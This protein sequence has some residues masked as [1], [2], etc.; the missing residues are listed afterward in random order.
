MHILIVRRSTKIKIEEV[1]SLVTSCITISVIIAKSEIIVV[2]F[3]ET[4]SASAVISKA[5]PF[6]VV[7]MAVLVTAI[8][9]PIL[10]VI[11]VVLI[12]VTVAIVIVASTT[13]SV[14]AIVFFLIAAVAPIVVSW[15]IVSIV[16]VATY[17]G[18]DD[19]CLGSL[20][21]APG[22]V[23]VVL[24][25]LMVIHTIDLIL[26]LSFDPGGVVAIGIIILGCAWQTRPS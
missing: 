23:L 1:S 9:V 14:G 17:S 16:V 24:F 25:F 11:R 26:P 2:F 8:A 6:S 22:R 5:I 4:E 7:V 19:V 3:V 12:P 20:D 21:I 10:V 15:A 18:I 13:S